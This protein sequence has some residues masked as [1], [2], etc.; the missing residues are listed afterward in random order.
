M[1]GAVLLKNGCEDTC[2]SNVRKP[3]TFCWSRCYCHV[4]V[5]HDLLQTS[6]ALLDPARPPSIECNKAEI[7]RLVLLDI[8]P[9]I[10]AIWW[11]ST[12]LKHNFIHFILKPRVSDTWAR[13][14]DALLALCETN[15]SRQ[16]FPLL[17]V[18]KQGLVNPRPQRL[19]VCTPWTPRNSLGVL[20]AAAVQQSGAEGFDQ[21]TR[22]AAAMLPPEPCRHVVVPSVPVPST[23]CRWK[24]MLALCWRAKKL[25]RMVHSGAMP[26]WTTE[27]VDAWAAA[28][29]IFSW[30]TPGQP[31]PLSDATGGW[32]GRQ[33]AT[34]GKSG[35]GHGNSGRP[36]RPHFSAHAAADRYPC[37]CPLD[38][39]SRLLPVRPTPL[40]AAVKKV[41]GKKTNHVRSW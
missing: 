15:G 18:G 11:T 28:A 22:T 9:C 14:I 29:T 32:Q 41:R 39:P 21:K 37:W 27:V 36:R 6:K 20:G 25:Q 1:W 7:F 30:Q 35:N 24:A 19:Q 26:T 3:S 17:Q 5:R 8:G 34:T 2:L 33:R 23:W 38:L 13:H 4:D 12:C 31:Q 40:T 16:D 10:K